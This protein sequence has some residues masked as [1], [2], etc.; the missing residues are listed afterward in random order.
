MV[1]IVPPSPQEKITEKGGMF[2]RFM[3]WTQS[4][5]NALNFATIIDG[6]GSPNGVISAKANKQY[7][8]I[9]GPTLYWK[10]VDDVAGDTTLGWVVIV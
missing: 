4:I 6:T 9:S 8:D 1:D 10:S 5:T 7:R 2:N 3:I